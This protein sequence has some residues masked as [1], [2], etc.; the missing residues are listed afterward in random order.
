MLSN[1]SREELQILATRTVRKLFGA[2]ELLFSEVEPCGD[3][4]TISTGK[5]R[6]FKT[7][8]N[9]REQVL[10]VNVPGESVDL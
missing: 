8:V 7:S 9:G 5:V 2:G 10:A 6:I 3:L 4:H 1:L